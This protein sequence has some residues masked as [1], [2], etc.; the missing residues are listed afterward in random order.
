M[1]V[2]TSL[3][4]TKEAAKGLKTGTGGLEIE[5]KEKNCTTADAKGIILLLRVFHVYAD[6][7]LFVCPGQQTTASLRL[8]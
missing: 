6:T 5:A 8:W 4:R 1:K 7:R 3:S 2:S